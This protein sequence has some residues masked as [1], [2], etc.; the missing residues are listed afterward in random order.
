MCSRNQG[1]AIQCL[2]YP[3]LKNKALC[4]VRCSLQWNIVER[5]Q[6]GSIERRNH[7]S[8]KCEPESTY[9]ESAADQDTRKNIGLT[10]SSEDNTGK[11]VTKDELQDT[12]NHQ[13]HAPKEGNRATAF[14]D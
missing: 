5:T 12:P 10:D 1:S 2:Y 8:S 7:C 14:L 13:Q 9:S 3:E 4:N 6:T 11:G